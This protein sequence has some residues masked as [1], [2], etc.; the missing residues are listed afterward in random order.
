MVYAG[1][2]GQSWFA[3]DVYDAA[4]NVVPGVSVTTGSPDPTVLP[5]GAI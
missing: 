1:Y 3:L 4:G 5:E 2:G